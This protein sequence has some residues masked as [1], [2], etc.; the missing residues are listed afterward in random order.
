MQSSKLWGRPGLSYPNIGTAGFGVRAAAAG[1]CI[2]GSSVFIFV[3]DPD[4]RVATL[5]VLNAP[6]VIRLYQAHGRHRHRETISLKDLPIGRRQL[7]S[8]RE[9][10]ASQAFRAWGAAAWSERLDET[11]RMFVG[12]PSSLSEVLLMPEFVA[13]QREIVRDATYQIDREVRRVLGLP[14]EIRGID[15]LDNW[16]WR[17]TEP[18]VF[19]DLLSN[20]VGHVFGRFAQRSDAGVPP[21]EQG[22]FDELPA[23]SPAMIAASDGI[24]VA[25]DDEGARG[26]LAAEVWSSLERLGMFD[27]G[28]PPEEWSHRSRE[29]IRDYFRRS[30]FDDH[31]VRYGQS[32][33]KAPIYWQLATP[34]ASYSLWLYSPRLTNDSLYRVLNDYVVPKL[35]HEERKQNQLVQ[36]AG[37]SPTAGKRTEIDAQGAFVEELRVFREELARVAPLWN[38]NQDDG[39]MVNFAP[40]WRLVPQHRAWQKE[41]KNCW[42]KLVAGDYDWAH[43]AM[44]VWPER[45]VPKCACDRSLAIAHGLERAFWQEGSDGRWRTREI[46]AM[47]VHA[48]IAEHSSLAVKDALESLIAAP[49]P[50]GGKRGRAK[51]RAS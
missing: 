43:L 42:D 22:P 48:I 12:L 31:L 35:Q 40:L 44:R 50:T 5:G 3:E 33:R 45:V 41:C 27:R 28:R 10:V 9:A 26:D 14:S 34:S 11:S 18:S 49:A 15:T 29:E 38:P 46:D 21:T 30:F 25:V 8:L 16:N 17:A 19:R 6:C 2:A 39:V 4:L 1:E 37:P 32:G 23:Q 47:T 20:V 51:P 36:S 24:D 13:Q 7:D